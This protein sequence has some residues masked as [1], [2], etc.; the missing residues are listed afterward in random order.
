MDSKEVLTSPSRVSSESDYHDERDT[1]FKMKK[2]TNNRRSRWVII[3]LV[4]ALIVSNG[5]WLWHE[6]RSSHLF[7]EFQ[8]Q[9]AKRLILRPQH[10]NTPFSGENKT[11]TNALWQGLF[12]DG[13]GLVHIPRDYAASLQLP[14]SVPYQGNASERVYF[15]AAYH[16]IHCLSVIR[17]ALYH[18]Q[19][20][21]PQTVPIQHTLHCLDSLRQDTMCHAEKTLLYTE[22]GKVFGDGQVR[23]C[24]DWD[25]L[26]DWIARHHI[27][28]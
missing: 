3:F 23:E 17:A 27:D 13:A 19:E 16:N 8:T 18:F 2:E 10:W 11:E 14:H 24:R 9:P 20:G 26:N 5:T 12:P 22:N 4:V 15:V 6:K 21:V 7:S 28:L 25:A 1:F